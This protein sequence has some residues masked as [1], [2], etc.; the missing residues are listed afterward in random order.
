MNAFNKIFNLPSHVPKPKVKKKIVK[1]K[2]LPSDMSISIVL[3]SIKMLKKVTRE[4]FIAYTGLSKSIVDR[5]L[6]ILEADGIVKREQGRNGSQKQT[7]ITF[8]K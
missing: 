2:K 6:V 3:E 5:C 7:T 8:I 1:V 4:Y